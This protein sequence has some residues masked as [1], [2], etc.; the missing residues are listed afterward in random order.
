M[1]EE[2]ILVRQKTQIPAFELFVYKNSLAT[3]A[4][5]SSC[6]VPCL[7]ALFGNIPGAK[8]IP[9]IVK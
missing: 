1:Q 2:T 8:G 6:L 5:H 9:Q 4:Q 3:H 7:F